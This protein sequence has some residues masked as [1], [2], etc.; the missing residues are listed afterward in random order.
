M[1]TFDLSMGGF[2]M[3]AVYVPCCP[4]I[5]GDGRYTRDGTKADNANTDRRHDLYGG[6]IIV[7]S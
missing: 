6:S 2:S 4:S 7:D 5:S 1:S 3:V